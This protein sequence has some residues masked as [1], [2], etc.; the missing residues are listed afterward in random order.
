MNTLRWDVAYLTVVGTLWSAL[1]IGKS[2]DRHAPH[3]YTVTLRDSLTNWERMLLVGC[4][5]SQVLFFSGL[6]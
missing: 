4:L 1:L 3:L 6:D 2:D 5:R